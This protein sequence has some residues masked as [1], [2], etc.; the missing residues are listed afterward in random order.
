MI[1][2]IKN[3]LNDLAGQTSEQL[4]QFTEESNAKLREQFTKLSS[5]GEDMKDKLLSYTNG[6]IDLLPII[7]E[8]GYRAKGIA[9]GIGLPPDVVFHFEKFKDIS[10]EDRQAILDKNKDKEFLALIVKTLVS[11][12]NFQSHRYYHGHTAVGYY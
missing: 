4:K 7:E 6:L 3:K 5:L 1:S 11:A 10:A 9:V 8:C 2:N 12:D